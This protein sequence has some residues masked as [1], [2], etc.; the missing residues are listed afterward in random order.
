MKSEK[1]EVAVKDRRR[2]EKRKIER[3]SEKS[4]I[5]V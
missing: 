2:R 5:A 4:L 1:T 3:K